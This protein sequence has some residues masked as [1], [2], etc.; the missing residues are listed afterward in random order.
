[1][2]NIYP[3]IKYQ[4]MLDGVFTFEKVNLFCEKSKN[5]F[6]DLLKIVDVN[7][8]DIDKANLKYL[9]KQ[10]LDHE[11]YE[12]LIKPDVIEVY[13]S[14]DAGFYYATKTLKQIMINHE[15]RCVHIVDK[16]DLK[17][18]GFMHDISR[19]KVPKIETVKYIIDIMS[20]LKMN[21]LELYVE[22]FSFEYKSFPQYL[23]DECYIT[24]EEYKEIEKYANDRFIDFVPNQNGFGHM[25]DWLAQD[26]F[27]DLA[28]APEGIH[29]W[30]THRPPS[31][32]N[33]LDPKSI[34]LIK[35][36]YKDMLEI[37]NSK[38]FNMNFDE[39][40]ELG[41]NKTKE[42]CLEFGEGKVYMDYAK[43]AYDIIK[44]HNK[45][46]LIWGDVLI[47]HD[48]VLDLIPKDMIFIDWGYEAESPFYSHLKK[49]KDANIKFMAAPATTSW[50][51]LLTRT[52]D[53]LENISS[54]IWNVY[55]LQGEGVLLTDWGDIGH[56]QFL[57]VSFAPLVYC[58]LLSY[59]VKNGTFKQLRDYLNEYIFKD[60]KKLA[61]DVFMDAGSYYKYEPRYTDNG[62][63]TFYSMVSMLHSFKEEDQIGYFKSKVKY[64]LFSK[65]QFELLLDFCK[66][67]KKEVK[68]CAIDEVFKEEMVNSLELLEVMAKLN[69]GYQEKVDLEYRL[70]ALQEVYTS[71]DAIINNFRKLWLIRNKYSHLDESVE[72][73]LKIK[74]FAMRSINYYRG[75][76]HGTQN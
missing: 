20:D 66:Q 65:E 72:N 50:C 9:D 34:E 6:E 40:F 5:V 75:G 37:S 52:Q 49:L 3:K 63:T 76:K 43:K 27:K 7:L 8:V 15:L 62:T 21:H 24:V 17:I 25:T 48:D 39:P 53:W 22:G 67:K 1:M 18:R 73:L 29:L 56:P 10:G 16:P 35:V 4:S 55:N 69:I 38:Y 2:Y 44:E 45:I 36:M 23:Q 60:E 46:P 12:I 14:G 11:E 70:N 74:E 41:K 71:I 28:E 61:A 33:A 59:R 47:K 42:A 19:N 58:G 13:A 30:G 64:N 54:A 57:P 26:E 51:T 68:M 31:T 32:L